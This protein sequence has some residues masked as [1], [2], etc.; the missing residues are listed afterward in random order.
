MK[1][2]LFIL[3]RDMLDAMS[4]EEVKATFKDMVELKIASPPYRNFTIQAPMGTLINVD[5]KG[6]LE[7]LAK[8]GDPRYVEM[9]DKD[10]RVHF[11]D[12]TD[13]PYKEQR[14]SLDM[15]HKGVWCPVLEIIMQSPK[16]EIR[17]R[18]GAFLRAV[19]DL[20]GHL[21]RLLI[22]SLATRNVE[23]VTRR[24]SLAK[25]GLGKKRG[26]DFEYVTTIK[27][28]TLLHYDGETGH[29]GETK[30]PHLRRGHIRRQHYGPNNQQIKQVFIQ[31]IFVNGFDPSRDRE[32]DRY[33]VT[34]GR[35]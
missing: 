19:S 8:Q 31:P 3:D 32:R 30:R 9:H 26:H 16:E 24:N 12:Y 20:A 13:D 10:L 34:Q 29:T 35:R 6:T 5:G 11:H 18:Y 28:G 4:E 27:M 15:F 7:E 23:T 1:S 21:S 2:Q 33:N 17:Q 22:V 25:F 14:A